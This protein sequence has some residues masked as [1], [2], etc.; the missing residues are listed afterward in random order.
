MRKYIFKLYSSMMIVAMLFSSCESYL[1]VTPEGQSKRD[2]QLSTADGIQD[3]LYGCYASMRSDYLYGR[4]LSFQTM[5]VLAQYLASDGNTTVTQMQA[6]NYQHSY[7]KGIFENMWTAMYENIAYTNSI[8]N[9]DLVK[10]ATTFPFSI[11]K[12]EA[13]ALRAYMHFDLLRVFAKQITLYPDADGI[14]YSKEFSLN[15]PDFIPAAKVYENILSDLLEAEKLLAN[16]KE[17]EDQTDFMKNRNIHMNIYA[18]K[19]LLARVYLT[20]GDKA[21]AA[22]YALDVINNSGKRLSEKTEVNGDLAGILSNNETLFGIYYNDFYSV[23]YPKLQQQ[24]TFSSLDPRT[25][26]MTFYEDK[27]TGLDYRTTAYFTATSSVSAAA[28]RLSKLT[29]PYELAN[30]VAARPSTKIPGINM[31]RLPEMYYIAA[32]CLLDSDYDKAVALFDEALTHRGLEPLKNWPTPQNI[33]TVSAITDERN[34]ELIG[35]GQ[36]FFNMKRLN[37]DIPA[38]DGATTIKA[39][40]DIYVVPIPDIEHEYRN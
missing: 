30:N 26:I 14:P 5:E 32:E 23:V 12:G 17:Y 38:Y 33:L 3:A 37:M 28:Y 39:S 19:A 16:E 6:Y 31:L 29:D 8:L 40:N 21:K 15:T 11:Y 35:E 34:R 25:D 18:V 10:D 22:Q 7:V 2:D 24:V 36:A 4:E 1:D 27:V 9:C 13:L 20:M